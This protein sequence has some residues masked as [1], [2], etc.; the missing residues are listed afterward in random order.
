MD[1]EQL[2]YPIGKFKRPEKITAEMLQTCIS[3]I[4]SF[5]SRLQQKLE[6]L[7]KDG[8]NKAYR[9]GSWTVRQVVNHCADSHMNGLVRVKLA[10]TEDKPVIKPYLEAGWAELEDSNNFPIE[11]ALKILDGIHARW[12]SLLNSLTEDQWQRTFIHPEHGKE[13]TLAENTCLYAWH[14]D[15]HLGHVEIVAGKIRVVNK[16]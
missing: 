2:M 11:P 8:L 6:R 9:P 4:S 10:L 16:I 15:H 1:P 3:K 14:C 13:I 5:P 12:S 7:N